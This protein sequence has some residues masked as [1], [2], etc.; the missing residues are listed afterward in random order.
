MPNDGAA[1][2]M[3]RAPTRARSMNSYWNSSITAPLRDSCGAGSR[4]D[5]RGFVGGVRMH[6][7]VVRGGVVAHRLRAGAV[8]GDPAV[9]H[10]DRA[11]D[12][13]TQGPEFVGDEQRRT[14]AGDEG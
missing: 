1:K 6:V 8:V 14:A 7:V 10:H 5:T 12:Q 11:G 3:T 9:V 4:P 2:P 13:R